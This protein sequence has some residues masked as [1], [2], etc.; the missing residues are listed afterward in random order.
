MLQLHEIFSP[1]IVRHNFHYIA[2]LRM[3]EHRAPQI[4]GIG[5][6]SKMH[7]KHCIIICAADFQSSLINRVLVRTDR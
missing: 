6:H 2:G 4:S 7:R 1:Q 3:R 5:S